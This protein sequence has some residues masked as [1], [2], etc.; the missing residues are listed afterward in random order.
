MYSMRKT[1][2]RAAPVRL[3]SICVLDS[4]AIGRDISRLITGSGT[5]IITS[6]PKGFGWFNIFISVTYK[7]D[8]DNKTV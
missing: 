4:A 5:Q 7:S 6:Y 8:Y 3:N 2:M 1:N